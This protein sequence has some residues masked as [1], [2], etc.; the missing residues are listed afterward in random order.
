MIRKYI[1]PVLAACGVL[2]AIFMVRAGNKPPKVAP[3]V[4]EPAKPPFQRY[5]AGSGI[6]EAATENIAIGTPIAGIVTDVYAR[7]GDPIKAG[8]PHEMVR[9]ISSLITT[10]R[11]D[12]QFDEMIV[13][14]PLTQPATRPADLH[15][16]L[17]APVASKLNINTASREQ[18][19]ALPGLDD[20]SAAKIIAGRPYLSIWDLEGTALFKIDDRQARSELTVR[21]A[22]AEQARQQLAKA[23]E[24]TR[25]EELLVATA[26]LDEAKASYEMARR[27]FVRWSSVED[28]SAVAPEEL[29]NRKSM[30][31]TGAAKVRSMEATLKKLNAGTWAP[32]IAISQAE[33]QSAEAEVRKAQTEIDRLTVRAPV[34]GSVLQVKVRP[35]E[36]AP[37]GVL[38]TPLMLVGQTDVLHIRVD[39]DEHEAMRVRPDAEAVASIRG[40]SRRQAKLRF[41]AI[42]PYVIPK[43]SLTG[44]S[45]E[46]VDT[47]VLQIIYAFNPSDLKAYVGQQMDVFIDAVKADEERGATQPATKP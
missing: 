45:S 2:F 13:A 20:A 18:L 15:L 46:R 32:D 33:L 21:K 28:A 4:A 36:Y 23:L 7:V 29:A 6:I 41:V 44:D 34:S 42:E 1:L 22:A 14:A 47:R 10:G 31:E 5:V 25:S 26:Q 11:A 19:A 12:E 38:Q 39:V 30:M 40:D 37:S 9:R 27:N 35:G 16:D 8:L 43:K 24:G 17:N 3:P